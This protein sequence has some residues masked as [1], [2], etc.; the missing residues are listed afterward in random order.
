MMISRQELL[1]D[2]LA[3][4]WLVRNKWVE[5]LPMMYNPGHNVTFD[6]CLEP[7]RGCPFK[8]YIPSK[9]AKYGIKI[10]AAFDVRTS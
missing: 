10:W 7:F 6:E 1:N 3:A 5:R 8:Q 4:I 2:K 9:P